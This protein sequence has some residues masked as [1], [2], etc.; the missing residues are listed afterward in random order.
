MFIYNETY[1]KCLIDF[2]GC[3]AIELE[4]QIKCI[5]GFVLLR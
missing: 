5:Y 2:I 4:I 1:N 3:V